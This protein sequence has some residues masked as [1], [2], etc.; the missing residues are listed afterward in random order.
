M[1]GFRSTNRRIARWAVLAVTIVGVFLLRGAP[2]GAAVCAPGY[3]IRWV[4][5]GTN[6]LWENPDNWADA[7]SGAHR[8]PAAADRVCVEI[9]GT[10]FTLV[11]IT[12]AAK[13]RT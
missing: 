5:G 13:V 2:A 1:T 9:V 12:G 11:T 3:T 7:T 8:V 6:N 4:A 10:N